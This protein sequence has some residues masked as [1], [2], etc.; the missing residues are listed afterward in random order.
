VKI[1]RSASIFT[2]LFPPTFTER[3]MAIIAVIVRVHP[4]GIHATFA[5]FSSTSGTLT[6]GFGGGNQRIERIQKL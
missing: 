4:S 6:E 3:S 1:S 5:D 2:M